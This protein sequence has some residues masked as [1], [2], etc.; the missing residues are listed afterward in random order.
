[1]M[2]GI[3]PGP[4][5][6]VNQ[7]DWVYTIMI[8][9]IL[10]NIFMC[11]QGELFIK[12]F[13]NV[14]RIP[15]NMLIPILIIL[16]VIGSYAVNNTVFDVGVM[17][18]F[19]VVGYILTRL[20]FPITPMNI[21]IILGPLAESNLRRSLALSEGSYSIFIN[22]PISAIFLLLSIISF[23]TPIYKTYKQRKAKDIKD[24]I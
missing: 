17:L 3:T 19:G 21:A 16:C 1:M 10:V 2:Q 22:R 18:F 8:G 24:S 14:T 4:Q 15:A 7:A 23:V 20:D 5:L 12:A 9:L 6:F 13:V 11:L